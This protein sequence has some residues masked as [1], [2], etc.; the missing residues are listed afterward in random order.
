MAV[1]STVLDAALFLLLVSAG[2]A[3]VATQ[4]APPDVDRTAVDRADAVA[5]TLSASTATVNYTLAPGLRAESA[6]DPSGNPELRRTA[7]GTLTGLLAEATVARATVGDRRV[8]RTGDDFVRGVRR[9]VSAAAE[10]DRSGVQVIVRWQPYPGAHVAGETVVGRSP[11]AD[12]TVRAATVDAPSAFPSARREARAAAPDGFDAVAEV[13]AA[14]L[15]AG[16]V[17]ADDARLALHGDY[18]VTTLMRA[19]YARLGDLY[20][21]NVSADV[22]AGDVRAANRKLAGAAA[23]R[24]EADLRR[25]FD[26][27]A[28]AARALELDRV[29]V[30]VRTWSR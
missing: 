21:A 17:P 30:V 10:A 16:L 19:R 28:A 9:R 25:R 27:P 2:A 15:V 3:T 14:R 29:R 24:V 6:A 7:H 11:P 1:T 4:T 26:S 18:P 20:G 22:A 8:S 12:A 13:V 23:G 5:E